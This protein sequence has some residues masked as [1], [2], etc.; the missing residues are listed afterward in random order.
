MNDSGDRCLVSIFCNY[1][2]SFHYLNSF[3][4]DTFS[5]YQHLIVSKQD[6]YIL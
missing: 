6:Y 2:L 5:V 4:Y 3:K 1:S